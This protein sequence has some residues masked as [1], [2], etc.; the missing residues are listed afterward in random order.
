MHV[1][2]LNASYSAAYVESLRTVVMVV[3]SPTTSIYFDVIVNAQLV[4]TDASKTITRGMCAA[5]GS[6]MYAFFFSV[7]YTYMIS[8]LPSNNAL[9]FQLASV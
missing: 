3:S 9:P 6:H 4:M 5:T 7:R 2:A 1:F 8:Q